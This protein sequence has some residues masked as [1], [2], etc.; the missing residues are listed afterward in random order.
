MNMAAAYESMV[1]TAP[2]RVVSET[3][4]EFRRIALEFVERASAEES[5]A[6]AIDLS[7][8]AEVDASGLGILVLVQKRAKELGVHLTLRKVPTQVRYLLLLTKL[9]HLFEFAD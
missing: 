5:K 2:E 3:R 8:T 4:A 6:A 9:D 7:G 1:L